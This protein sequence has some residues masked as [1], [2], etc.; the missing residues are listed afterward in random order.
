MGEAVDESFS[1]MTP[2]DTHAL[3][4]FVRSVPPIASPGLPATLAPPAPASP[5]DDTKDGAVASNALG[6]KIFAEACVSCHNWT[7]VSA[8]TPFATISGARAV[9]DPAATNVAQIV[10]SGTRRHEPQGVVSMPAF[11]DAYSD[12]EIAAVAN[13]VTARFGGE[14]SAV[15]ENDVAALR[16]QTSR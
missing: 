5:K 9:N 2:E 3:V 15:T 11:G 4:A 6:R 7:G 8:I 12:T 1:Q 13:Y 16:Q 10:I 14:K